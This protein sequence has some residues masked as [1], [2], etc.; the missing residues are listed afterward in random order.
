AR[1]GEPTVRPGSDRPLV[2]DV[3]LP[4]RRGWRDPA[5]GLTLLELGGTVAFR[6]RAHGIDLS[7]RDAVIELGGGRPSRATFVFGGQAAQET[8]GKRADLVDLDPAH[9][10][11]R[12]TSADGRTQTLVEVPGAVPAGTTPL[13]GFYAAGDPFGWMTVTVTT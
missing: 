2:Y 4:L 11:D 6:Y 8:R 10:T 7:V 13:S 12:R 5:S 9:A 1:A 3:A